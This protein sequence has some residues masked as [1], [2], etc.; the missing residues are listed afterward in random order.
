MIKTEVNEIMSDFVIL[1]DSCADLTLEL[2]QELGIQPL[3][4]SF[5]F[6]GDS[7]IYFNHADNRD[8]QPKAF[9]DLLRQGKMASTSAVNVAAFSEAIEEV[10]R[11]EKD[12]LVLDFSGALSTTCNSARIAAEELM[13]SYPQRRACVV[14]TCCA[15]V[16]QGLLVWLAVQE[17]RKGKSL[18]EV[19][20][21]AEANKLHICH[22]V[23]VAELDTLKR[24]G[25][26]SAT[27]AVVG[28]MLNIKPV[29]FI[30]DEGKLVSV[31]KARGRSAAM[32]AIV[33]RM[34]ERLADPSLPVFISH[35]DCL[36]D[37]QTV[38]QMVTE[39]FGI[40]DIRYSYVGPVI[41]SHTGPGVIA[42]CYMGK[43]RA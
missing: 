13:E 8:M 27:T 2:Y 14:D 29:I 30:D 18:E 41:G 37:A 43:Q 32:K 17:Q 7:A 23:T 19:R 4:L 16:G 31:A 3:P 34:A 12:V 11:Q 38:G 24:G 28:T 9:Y 33:D 22:E 25:R 20:D 35:G 26:I 10:F 5:Q 15:S 21:W 6:K 1:T 39:R 36:E 40:T 42:L